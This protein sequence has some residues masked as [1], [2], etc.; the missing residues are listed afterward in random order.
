MASIVL[1]RAF[2]SRSLP[3]LRPW[4]RISLNSE[5]T[6]SKSDQIESLSDYLELE[7]RVFQELDT[8]IYKKVEPEN[9]FILSRYTSNSPVNPE[10]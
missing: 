6:E 5:F 2:D 8:S 7:E 3:D 1:V 4:H 10:Q 9:Q